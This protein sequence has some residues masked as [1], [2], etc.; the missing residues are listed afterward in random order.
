MCSRTRGRVAVLTG[1]GISAESGIPTFRDATSRPLGEDSIRCSSPPRMAF[2]PIR[3]WF[4]AGMR[5]G[6]ALVADAQPNAGHV[7]LAAA[8][9]RFDSF[10][11]DYAECRRAACRA[12]STPIELHGNLMRTI[13]LARC[14]FVEHDLQRLPAGRAA[15]LSRVR[16]LATPGR[17]LVRR[18]ARCSRRCS[19][20]RRRS[21]RAT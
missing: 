6:A 15:A 19:R 11:L 7:A 13:C 5:G 4:G 1:A 8:Q 18:D 10:E 21:A 16:R 2:G 20:R 9:S 3:R 17:G 12:G 14:G